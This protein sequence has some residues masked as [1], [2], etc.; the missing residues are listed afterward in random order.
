MSSMLRAVIP[1]AVVVL[2]LL[3]ACSSDGDTTSTATAE[4]E[5]TAIDAGA[6]DE[7]DIVYNSGNL[8]ARSEAGA[9]AASVS[10]TNSGLAISADSV[11]DG[12]TGADAK[13]RGI[14]LGAGGE[15]LTN[16]GNITTFSLA[17]T[18]SVGV[19]VAGDYRDA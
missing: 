15:T 4:A 14:Y 2:L 19:A 9:V 16:D 12:G 11:W 6:G 10:I 18:A 3:V 13:S 17:G 1:P 7:T 8:T 5:A